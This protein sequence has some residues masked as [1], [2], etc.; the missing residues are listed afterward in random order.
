MTASQQRLRTRI[1][2]V[3]VLVVAAAVAGIVLATRSAGG[4]STTSTRTDAWVLP[5][6]N[7]SGE[8][9]LADYRGRPLVVNFFASW[10]TACQGELP[11]YADLSTRLRGVVSF[12]GVDSEETGDGLALA[13]RYG[14]DWW[15][16]ARDVEGQ[17][18]SGLHDALGGQGMPISA[19][20]DASGRV[21]YVSPG[22]LNEDQVVAILHDRL[23]VSVPGVQPA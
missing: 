11:G 14:V 10:C 20:Y 15:P 13:R 16:L 12:V 9:S 4:S 19:F 18:A 8:V 7:G 17:Q 23:G 6:L 3:V 5:R 2:L 21:V 1:A 22:A